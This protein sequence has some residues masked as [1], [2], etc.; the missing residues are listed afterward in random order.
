MVEPHSL[1]V[2][3]NWHAGSYRAQVTDA[4]D[5]AQRLGL[6]VVR[7]WA[8]CDGTDQYSPLQPQLGKLNSTILE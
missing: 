8:F 7:M 2:H 4:L 3:G 5:L 6:I 1:H